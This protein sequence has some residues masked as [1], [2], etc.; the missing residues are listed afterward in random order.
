VPISTYATLINQKIVMPSPR[1]NYVAVEKD[2][3]VDFFKPMLK[4]ISVD[5]EWYLRVNPDIAEAIKNKIVSSAQEH[6]VTSGYYEHRMPYEITVDEP[7]YLSQYADIS[8]AVK[9]GVFTS[10]KE[11]FYIAGY[12]EGRLPSAHF[13]LNLID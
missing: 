13:T 9:K 10:A 7:W 5:S 3:M 11:H 12:R 1:T 4:H 6:Y 8:D 2:H